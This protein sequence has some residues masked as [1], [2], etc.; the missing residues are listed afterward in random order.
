[1]EQA[2]LTFIEPVKRASVIEM[3]TQSILSLIREG[4]LRPG[5]KLPS[6]KE[7]QA[8]LKVSRPSLREALNGLIALGYLE[9]RPGQGYYVR[10]VDV[11]DVLDFSVVATLLTED[12]IRQLFEARMYFEAYFA[13]LAALRITPQEV[14]QLYAHVEQI[15]AAC[16]EPAS[17]AENVAVGMEFHQHVVDTIHNPILS[18]IERSLLKLFTEKTL[19]IYIQR[20]S[21][22]LDLRYHRKIV[23]ALEARDPDRASFL[24]LQDISL[25]AQYL[26]VTLKMDDRIHFPEDRIK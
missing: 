22:A 20:P 2:E 5:D 23:E 19:S 7:L 26:G 10:T 24:A 11:A 1:M 9:T 3:V 12:S 15:E 13:R 18:D 25:Y 8:M 14:Q 16:K 17:I 4:A 21:Q 6:Q